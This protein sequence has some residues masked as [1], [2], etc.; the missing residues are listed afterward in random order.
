[1][2]NLEEYVEKVT[3]EN[4]NVLFQVLVRINHDLQKEM[5]H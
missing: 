5:K 3:Q 1:M 2:D 4:D